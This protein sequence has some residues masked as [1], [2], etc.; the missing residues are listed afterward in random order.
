LLLKTVAEETPELAA[1]A[2]QRRLRGRFSRR[3]FD[4]ET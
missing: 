3:C 1:M 4:S 2:P